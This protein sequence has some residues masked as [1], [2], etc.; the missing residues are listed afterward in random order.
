MLFSSANTS[1]KKAVT[2]TCAT[3]RP[4]GSGCVKAQM[5]P[6][7]PQGD[8]GPTGPRGYRGYTGDTGVTG[9]TG[10]TGP[11]GDTGAMGVPG[12]ASSTGATGPIGPTGIAGPTNPIG[13]TL[14]VDAVYGNDTAAALSPYNTPFLTIQ[15][16]LNSATPGKNVRVLAGTY[17]ESLVMSPGVSLT[18]DSVQTVVIQKPN[19]SSNTTLIT[20]NTNCRVENFSAIL[21]SSGNYN[22]T[23]IRYPSGTSQNSKL[24]NSVWNITSTASG[25]PT[26]IGALSDGS[27]NLVYS[28]PNAIQRTTFNVTSSGLGINRGLYITGANRFTVRDIVVYASGSGNNI[29]GAEIIDP[30]G[31]LEIKTSTIGG[32]TST[33]GYT[34]HDIY[35]RTGILSVGST[36][37]VYNDA[38]DN[39]FTPLQAPASFQFGVINAL[40][41]NQR[42]YLLPGTLQQ[43][44]LTR[45]P[46]SNTYNS[47]KAFPIY[48]VN[49]SL[50]ILLNISYTETISG[51]DSLTFY[52]YKN[53]NSIPVYS[54]VLTAGE[55]F[56]TIT[57][58][59]LNY[60]AG[61]ILT[62]TLEVSGNPGGT[63]PAF[64]AIVGYY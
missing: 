64:N 56:L 54:G 14:T 59:S 23:G 44:A 52:L 43:S 50:V 1:K 8:T 36:D 49:D 60:N 15:A 18:G 6:A 51:G 10:P 3:F 55:K 5:G 29:I 28:T 26:I 27:S 40:A 22:L 25:S 42:Y 57:N 61:D 31:V 46:L 38:S 63:Y 17:N 19:V 30:S 39:S 41:S 20:M 37:L 53:N 47:V 4:N 12:L 62:A 32:Y 58:K 34:A 48:I 35:R 7:G 33:P 16:A 24:R 21:S 11:Q 2:Q 9:F 45:E 13:N